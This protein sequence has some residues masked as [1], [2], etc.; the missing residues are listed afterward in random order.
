MRPSA[1]CR[2]LPSSAISILIKAYCAECTIIKRIIT[3]KVERVAAAGYRA[4]Q[5]PENK[6]DEE[7]NRYLAIL[8]PSTQLKI[9]DYNRVLKDLNGRTPEQF[10]EELKKVFEI[11]ELPAQAHPTKQNVV[12]M[13][14]GGKWFACEFKQEYLQ[15]LGPVDSLDVALL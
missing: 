14:L 3:G 8:F 9:L 7:Y 6:G 15:D 4:S 11:S 2:N 5:N 13:Y 12:N 1:C 10:M